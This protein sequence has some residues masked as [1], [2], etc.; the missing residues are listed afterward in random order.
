MDFIIES[1]VDGKGSE[2]FIPKLRAYTIRDLKD[3]L[4]DLLGNCDE[5]KIPI[6]PGEKMHEVLINE[7]EIRYTWEYCNKY[8]IFNPT[9][10]EE[11]SHN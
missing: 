4:M 7:D 11:E 5:R 3:S 10:N 2:I 8:V 9:K 6:R 1:T